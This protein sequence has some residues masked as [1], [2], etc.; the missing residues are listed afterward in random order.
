MSYIFLE[1]KQILFTDFTDKN[2]TSKD[3]LAGQLTQSAA[4]STNPKWAKQ[5]DALK[6]EE[7]ISESGRIFFRNL[8]YTVVENDL[9]EVFEPY[10]PIVEV[11]LPIDSVTRIIKVTRG[12]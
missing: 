5:E 6:S 12:V 3:K 2:K 10:G 9:K 1:G 11:N 8:P 7:D 4:V